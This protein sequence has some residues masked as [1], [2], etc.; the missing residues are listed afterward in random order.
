MKAVTHVITSFVGID[1]SKRKLDCA[2]LINGKV[3]SKVLS[4]DRTGLIQLDSW[5][6]ERGVVCDSAHLSLEATG[7]YSEQV[8]LALVDFGWR[9]SVVNP[10]RI[11]GFAQ[12][13][14]A[15]NK[16]DR[17]DAALLAR[18]CAA[19]CP[20]LWVPPS[21]AYRQLCALVERLQALKDMHQQECNRLEAHHASG[22]TTVLP[23]VKSHIAWLDEQIAQLQRTISDHIDGHPE[24]KQDA[25]L[26]A[27]IPGIGDTTVAKVLAYAGNVRRF[28]NAKALAAFIGICPR[29]R[30]SGSSV[31][32][33][34]MISRTGHA[35]LRK[36]LYMPGLVALR[37]NPV[38][39][40]F[41]A[42]M[43]ANGLAPKAV[44]GAAMRKLAHLIYGVVKSGK[45]FDAGFA[46][47]RVAIQDGI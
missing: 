44:V 1:V 36:A 26:I 13:E 33:R 32:G 25:E 37:H 45:P 18:F 38:L 24:L 47:G 17:A 2:V 20:S 42:R 43:K 34:T 46:I 28:A 8:A 12:S 5:L 9:V 23:N 19:M 27:S 4:N 6:Q 14:L 22:E 7:P 31:R 29:Q 30:Q 40:V 3:K 10:A 35:D 39:K 15:R 21:P 11:K 16:T 41:G